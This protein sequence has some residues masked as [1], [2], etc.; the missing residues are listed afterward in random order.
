MD[1]KT[2][3][4]IVPALPPEIA[5]LMRGPTGVGKS[6]VAKTFADVL[7]L[8]FIDV[9]GSTMDEAKVG[10]LPDMKAVDE[11]KVATFVVPSWFKRACDDPCVIM[12]DELNRSMPTVMQA[13]FQIVLDRELGNDADGVPWRLHPETRVLAAINAGNEYDVNEMDPALLRRF[14]VCDVEPTVGDWVEW[15]EEAELDKI[16]IE[17]IKQEPAHWRVDPSTVEPGVVCPN[18]ASWHRLADSLVHMDLAPAK[19]AGNEVPGH[20]YSILTGFVGV[21]ASIAFR[22]FV[23][24]YELQISAEDILSGKITADD[25]K[26]APAS[27]ITGL[28]EKLQNHSKENNWKAKQVKAVA[29]FAE[30]LGGEFLIQTF[31][32]VQR[33]GNMKNLLPLNK[34]IGMKVVELVNEARATSK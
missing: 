25:V 2:L 23:A 1:I 27:Q 8:P 13:F 10:G 6:H 20:F 24:N 28:I 5:V 9:R 30:G 12:L 29:A 18:P 16:V 32:A 19:L 26:D 11:L 34:T 22:D 15:A 4:A 33:A 14:W 31:T 17:F 7:G 21:E 3:K